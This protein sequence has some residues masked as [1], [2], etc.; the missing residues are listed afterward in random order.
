MYTEFPG[1]DAAKVLLR[2][3]PVVTDAD[4]EEAV[5]EV[6]PTMGWMISLALK[7]PAAGRLKAASAALAAQTP[8]GR[9]ALVV[10]GEVFTMPTV[11]CE[12]SNKAMV[13][14]D[15]SD[16]APPGTPAEQQREAGARRLAA[17]LNPP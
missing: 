2:A 4:I 6:H 8:K 1:A 15:F 3:K 12:L 10:K 17:A 9:I 11:Q 14:G 7:P 5:A 13:T 16:L